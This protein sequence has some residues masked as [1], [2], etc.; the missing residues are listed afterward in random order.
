MSASLSTRSR[1]SHVPKRRPSG[2]LCLRRSG[3]ATHSRFITRRYSIPHCALARMN[4]GTI[5]LS[6]VASPPLI[7]CGASCPLTS[8]ART[9]EASLGGLDSAEACRIHRLSSP[10]GSRPSSMAS[11][12]FIESVWHLVHGVSSAEIGLKHS[13]RV[14]PS[15][16]RFG[17]AARRLGVRI[18]PTGGSVSRTVHGRGCRNNSRHGEDRLD[19]Q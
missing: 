10:L 9:S 1:A 16:T 18:A 14:A 11:S 15:R 13:G 7:S 19:D 5:T 4:I 8:S 17:V 2:F 12:T 3:H 6:P